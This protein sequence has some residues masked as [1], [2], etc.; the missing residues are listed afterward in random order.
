MEMVALLHPDTMEG[1]HVLSADCRSTLCRV[2]IEHAD[3]SAQSR[4]IDH[5]PM[6]PP[7]DGEMLI[8]RIDDDPLAP[9]TLVYLARPGYSLLAATPLEPA[10]R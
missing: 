9:H 2:E 6:E 4:L 7:F 8:R 1:S 3:A 5:L 10:A